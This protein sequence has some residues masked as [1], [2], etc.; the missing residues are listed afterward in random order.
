MPMH[1]NANLA[2][3]IERPIDL[4]HLARQTLG[5]RELEREILS[6]F[7]R[8]SV[9][10]NQRIE[11]SGIQKERMDLA[12][13]LKGSARAVGAWKVADAAD[14]VELALDTDPVQLASCLRQLANAIEEA[15]S[16]IT[17]LSPQN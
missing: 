9:Q 6:L 15:N 3:A 12:H 7:V 4:V 13:T 11:A 8:Q 2:P 16:V 5:D 1:A 10:L 17:T 14:K